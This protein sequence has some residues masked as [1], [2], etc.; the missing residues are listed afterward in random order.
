MIPSDSLRQA[1]EALDKSDLVDLVVLASEGANGQTIAMLV[2]FQNLD[3]A[4]RR[5]VRDAA[6]DL[7]NSQRRKSDDG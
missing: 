7:L 1:A 4:D 2:F 6:R 5:R 3:A